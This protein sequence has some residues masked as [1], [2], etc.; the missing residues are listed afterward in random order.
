V[1][2]EK[3]KKVTLRTQSQVKHNH[4]SKKRVVRG[5]KNECQQTVNGWIRNIEG[6]VDRVI[7]GR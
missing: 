5:M 7:K 3:F 1:V 6:W 2:R 4:E